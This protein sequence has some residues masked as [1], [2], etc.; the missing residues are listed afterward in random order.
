MKTAAKRKRRSELMARR[1]EAKWKRIVAS[2]KAVQ[3]RKAGSGVPEKRSSPRS[4]IKV[5]GCI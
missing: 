1:D 4:A 3:G 2:V 5:Q